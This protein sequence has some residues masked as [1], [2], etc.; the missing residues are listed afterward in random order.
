MIFK[1][2]VHDCINKYVK[3]VVCNIPSQEN[4]SVLQINAKIGLISQKIEAY[5]APKMKETF[6]V[7]VN[8]LDVSNIDI[9]QSSQNFLELKQI[10]KEL[11]AH[12]ATLKTKAE[13]EDYAERL[14]IQREED[15]YAAHKRTQQENL[16]AFQ[17]EKQAEIGIAGAEALG[18][19]VSHGNI[20]LGGN[21]FGLNPASI[22]AGITLGGAI[23]KNVA[24]SI[25]QDTSAIQQALNVPPKVP[26]TTYYI[27]DKGKPEGPYTVEMLQSFISEGRINGESLL[28]RQGM[29]SWEKAR[30]F[31]ELSGY[32]PPE[33]PYAKN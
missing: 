3:D 10:T 14:R 21:S 6:A 9:D 2:E 15:R 16:A 19:M 5:I 1:N 31:S 26:E 33:I 20:N 30:D 8:S 11:T 17:T 29:K 22:A 32:F 24:N 28:W 25:N 23:G 4:I 18:K 13:I 27:A 7:K 12:V